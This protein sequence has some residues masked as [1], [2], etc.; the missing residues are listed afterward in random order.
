MKQLDSLRNNY[1]LLIQ[2]RYCSGAALV[3]GW[4]TKPGR[5]VVAIYT[6]GQFPA[7]YVLTDRMAGG[8]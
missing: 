1:R 5:D 4:H 7:F 2:K 3:A 6:F 8:L